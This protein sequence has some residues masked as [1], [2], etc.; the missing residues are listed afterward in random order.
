MTVVVRDSTDM[1]EP[2][3]YSICYV[4]GFQTQPG[5]EWPVELL[6]DGAPQA[7]SAATV[8]SVAKSAPSSDSDTR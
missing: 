5:A 8:V 1:P 3:L 6:V 2:G 4:N 7:A